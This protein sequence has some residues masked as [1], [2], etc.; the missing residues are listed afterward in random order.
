[1]NLRA[2]LQLST[3]SLWHR[4]G[5]LALVTITLTLS[6]LL[7]LGIQ[8]LRTEVRQS[9]TST[10]ANTDLIVGARSGQLNLLLYSVFHIG[11]ATNNIDWATYESL[12]QDPLVKWTVPL[13][14]GDS[15][16]GY[17]VVGT[18]HSF[19]DHVSYGDSHPV[20]LTDGQWFNNLFDIVL[21]AEVARTL[22]HQVGDNVALS[23]GSGSVSF[24]NHDRTPFR[25]SGILATTGTPVDRSVYVSLPG[26]EAIHVGWETGVPLAGRVPSAEQLE[27]MALEPK[28]ITAMLVGLKNRMQTFR[29]Q[30]QINQSTGEPLTAILPGVALNELW[31]ILGQFEKTLLGITGFVVVTSLIGLTAVLLTLQVHR[32]QEITILRA[33]GA[34]PWLIASLYLLECLLL[35]LLASTLAVMSGYILIASAGPWLAQEFG[36]VLR[37]R[38]LDSVEWS[39]LASIPTAATLVGLLP[40][41][42]AWWRSRQSPFGTTSSE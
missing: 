39:I 17:R 27:N 14:L 21:G 9:F 24:M 19:L 2:S 40:A 34:S 4:R 30:R 16:R 26:L 3:A 42:R 32:R 22:Q 6:V 35:A 25:V 13:S 18:D 37:L 38:P 1:M 28:A 36:L 31:R 15:Y 20:E 23:H 10:I 41:L 29:L 33:A 11:D 5:I 8:Y 7:L 12:R